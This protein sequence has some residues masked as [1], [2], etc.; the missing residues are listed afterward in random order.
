MCGRF[1][2]LTK[3]DMQSLFSVSKELYDIDESREITPGMYYPI[4]TKAGVVKMLW[5]I[6]AEWSKGKSIINARQETVNIKEFFRDSFINRR[7][8]VKVP[9]FYEWDKHKN[10]YMVKRKD[11]KLLNMAGLY[12]KVGDENC[13]VVITQDATKE[14]AR[15]HSRLPFILE[16]EEVHE[17]LRGNQEDRWCS[18]KLTNN[19][20]W[21]LENPQKPEQGTLF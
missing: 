12:M 10:K 4:I 19:L 11:S 21:N 18:P 3:E 9:A 20:I 15:V 16:D 7:C 1:A 2:S 6:K 8:I 14:F 5:G 17:Y 13:F